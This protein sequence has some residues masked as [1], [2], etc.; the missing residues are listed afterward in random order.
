MINFYTK[1]NDILLSM[2]LGLLNNAVNISG[3]ITSNGEMTGKQRIAN[4][5]KESFVACYD[6]I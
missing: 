2:Y 6:V 5:W 1:I 3:Y 4:L